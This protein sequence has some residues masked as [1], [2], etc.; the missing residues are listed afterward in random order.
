MKASDLCTLIEEN[1]QILGIEL[2]NIIAF[3]NR[4]AK[5]LLDIGLQKKRFGDGFYYYGLKGKFNG[6]KNVDLKDDNVI[7]K[8]MKERDADL[9]KF[10]LDKN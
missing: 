2:G 3:R 5:Y 7:E 10:C 8:L 9:E 4:L 1:F 6:F